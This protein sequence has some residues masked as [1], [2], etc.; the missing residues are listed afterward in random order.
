M[1]VQQLL[2]MTGKVALVTGGSRGIG[3]PMAEALGEAGARIAISARK[4]DELDEAQAHFA[5]LSIACLAVRN[6]LSDFAAIPRLVDAVLG[7][8]GQIDVLVNNAGCNWGAAAEDHPDEAW[9]K[10]MNLDLTAPFFLSREVGKRSMIPRRAGKIINISSIAGLGG[11]PPASG[12]NTIAYNTAKGGLVNFTRTL[13]AEWGKYNIQVNAICPGFFPTR[14]SGKLLEVIEEQY[15]A[16]TPA[17]RLG[18][19][20]D[21]K[22]L[23]LLLASNASAYMTGLAIAVDGGFSAT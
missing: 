15:V 10:V 21:L 19:G 20:Q 7:H 6:D 8:Y 17:G 9:H 14:M 16:R 22:G 13:A 3:V 12:M 18:D 2:D 11:N 1:N 23:T 4:Q 5:K